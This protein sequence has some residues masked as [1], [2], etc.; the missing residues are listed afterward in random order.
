MDQ[1]LDEIVDGDNL[2]LY[3]TNTSQTHFAFHVLRATLELKYSF[4][5]RFKKVGKGYF[6]MGSPQSKT[7]RW[8]DEDQV[9]VQISKDFEIMETEVTQGQWW[10]VMGFNPSHFK[11]ETHCSHHLVVTGG[12]KLCPT[13]PVERV[14]W[15]DVQEFIK[16]LNKTAG[17][18]GCR[19]TLHDPPGCYRLPTE[20]EW[21]FAAR[22]TT[23][24]T[25]FSKNKSSLLSGLCLV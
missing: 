2:K 24:A 11:Q 25:C 10:K 18:S 3:F 7:D 23:G 9:K 17:V 22:G 13:H 16:R 6:V 8:R 5:P 1:I 12:E 4:F 15:N 19:G 20:A 21:E 14:S